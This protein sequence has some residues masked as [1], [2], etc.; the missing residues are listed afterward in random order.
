MP[1]AVLLDLEPRVI[2]AARAS[3]L[4]EHLRPDNLANQNAGA[5]NNWA[6]GPLHMDDA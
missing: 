4:G 3:P 5:S 6:N 1:R 2:D